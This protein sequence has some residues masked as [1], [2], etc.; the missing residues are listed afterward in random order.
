MW[1]ASKS[2]ELPSDASGVLFLVELTGLE[3]ASIHEHTYGKESIVSTNRMWPYHWKW[4][5]HYGYNGEL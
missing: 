4:K 1:F 3:I 5:Y 2:G